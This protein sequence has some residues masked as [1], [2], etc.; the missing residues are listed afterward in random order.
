M[1]TVDQERLTTILRPE[2]L[3]PSKLLQSMQQYEHRDDE[4]LETEIMDEII[5]TTRRLI[6]DISDDLDLETTVYE[7]DRPAEQS[8]PTRKA[9]RLIEQSNMLAL[10]CPDD[11]QIAYAIECLRL[12]PM[13]SVFV[14]ATNKDFLED[15]MTIFETKMARL[16]GGKQKFCPRVYP[17]HV[18]WQHEEDTL[19]VLQKALLYPY[20][21]A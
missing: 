5:A 20:E 10:F 3:S 2:G 11:D 8:T 17:T 21:A 9:S 15:R 13:M 19:P 14:A 1:H 16:F 6:L 12:N 18:R 4:A 7:Y